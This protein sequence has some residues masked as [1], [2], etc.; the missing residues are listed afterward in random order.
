MDRR[1]RNPGTPSGG[2]RPPR[3]QYHGRGYPLDNHDTVPPA[4]GRL[5]EIYYRR[6]RAAA[7]I[8]I[9]VVAVVIV[10]VLSLVGRDSDSTTTSATSSMTT[11]AEPTT[12]RSA[13]AEASTSSSS[14]SSS[15]SA[16]EKAVE[17]SSAPSSTPEPSDELSAKSTC[18]ITDL[19]VEASA[20]YPSYT[21]EGMPSFYM[22]VR[23]PTAADCEIDIS[24]NSLRFE[25][26]SLDTNQRIW[27]DIDC[28]DPAGVGTQTFK[29]GQERYFRAQWSRTT[30]SPD[31]CAVR[32]PVAPGSYYLHT[33]IGDNA[34]APFDFNLQ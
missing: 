30:S 19:Q 29:A 12:S 33:V 10:A 6:R 7:V 14:A 31:G 20:D 26:Y 16:E 32:E 2:S 25:V 18:E 4:D 1:D 22:K 9:I 23:N 24:Q 34:S 5:P 11:S 27:S 17:I 15:K 3:R 13:A 28:N 21:P 8:A